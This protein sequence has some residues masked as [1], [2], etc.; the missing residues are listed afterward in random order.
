M[1]FY[2][3]IKH[4]EKQNKRIIIDTLTLVLKDES[5]INI[6]F[7]SSDWCYEDNQT[8]CKLKGIFFNDEYANGK[9]SL[10]KNN[11]KE[12]ELEA[13]SL[14]DDKGYDAKMTYLEIRDDE[15]SWILD[16]EKEEK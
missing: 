8:Y 11:I 2:A 7:D 15:N 12:I 1:I 5:R 14:E 4:K 9:L 10:M 16:L 3:T 6:E 13:Y